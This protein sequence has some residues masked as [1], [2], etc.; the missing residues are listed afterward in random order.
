MTTDAHCQRCGTTFWR[1]PHETW[2]RLCLDCWKESKTQATYTC[3]GDRYS[4]IDQRLRQELA[5]W[6]SRAIRAEHSL[7][8]HVC[9]P[10]ALDLPT[11]K[12]IRALCHPDRHGNSQAANEVSQ[13]INELIRRAS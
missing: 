3:S 9:P 5:E 7:A 8:S 4:G 6:R 2:K 11:L 10:A 13:V 1:E 12:R